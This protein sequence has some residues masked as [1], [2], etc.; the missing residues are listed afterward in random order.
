[1]KKSQSEAAPYPEPPP[2]LSERAAALWREIGPSKADTTG[3]RVLLQAA[4]EC[5]DRG[6]RAREL[7]AS[8]GLTSTTKSTGAVHIHPLAKIERD[9]RAQFASIWASLGLNQAHVTSSLDYLLK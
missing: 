9:A 4:L 2:H 7:I 3:R 1:M 6:D 5:L 8:E